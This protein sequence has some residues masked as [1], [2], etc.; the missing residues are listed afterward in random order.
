[1]TD[2]IKLTP[3]KLALYFDHTLLR[4]NATPEDFAAFCEESRQYGF[5]MVAVNSGQTARCKALLKGSPVRVGAAIGFP[6]GQMTPAAKRFETQDALD[7]GADE[8]DYVVNL[9]ELKA[10]NHAFV[11]DEM[12]GIVALCRAYSATSKVIFE[13]CYLTD[14]EKRTLLKIALEVQPDFVK[15]STG[16]GTG[17]ATME[18][19]K[20]MCETVQ[21]RIG[22][23]AAGGIRDLDT[24]LRL[25]DMGVTRIGSTASVRIVETLKAR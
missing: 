10:G 23:K 8:I 14:A 20:L 17:G 13:N 12:Q 2:K 7:N 16:F 5:K 15:T 1:M 9:T 24:A 3:E 11:A 18:D 21:G 25:I 22:V 6:L 19:I 4:A